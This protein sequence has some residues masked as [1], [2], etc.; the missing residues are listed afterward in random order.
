MNRTPTIEV[1]GPVLIWARE[2]RGLTVA[3]AAKRAGMSETK[4]KA[5]EDGTGSPSLAQL[6]NLAQTYRRPLIVLLL[7]EVPSTFQPLTD[8]RSLPETERNQYSPELRDEIRRAIAQRE[9]YLELL[10]GM[11]QSVTQPALPKSSDSATL[12][13]QLR[14]VLGITSQEQAQ[15]ADKDEAYSYWRSRVEGLGVLVLEAS[16]VE[17]AEMRGLSLS[18]ALPHVIVV[19][20][21]DSPRGKVFTLLHELSH[22]CMRAEG[23]CDLHSSSQAPDDI[24]ILCN[25]VAGATLLPEDQVRALSVVKQHPSNQEWSEDE[26]LAIAKVSG[27][28]SSEAVLRRL[29]QLGLASKDEYERKREEYLVAY[30]EFRRNRSRKSKGGPAPHTIQLRDRGRPFVRSVFDAYGDGLLNL[31]EVTD[32]VGLRVKH[33]DKLQH[34]A[35]K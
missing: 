3:V 14:S 5:V 10:K 13:S 12:A 17:L 16:R 29:V 32:L 4:L 25:A 24:E 15:L 19:N 18:D 1:S 6:R 20:G 31:S 11:D 7:D 26:I 22:L 27:G 21:K 28:A 9:V 34:E 30:E 23:V 2:Q 35:F 8:Y 33:L